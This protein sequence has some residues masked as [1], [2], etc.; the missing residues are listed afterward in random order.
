MPEHDIYS[1]IS[2]YKLKDLA[3]KVTKELWYLMYPCFKAKFRRAR[4]SIISGQLFNVF[5]LISLRKVPVFPFS[6][7]SA[8]MLS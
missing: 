5:S 7:N 4:L 6:K 1:R 2:M 3:N 8:L